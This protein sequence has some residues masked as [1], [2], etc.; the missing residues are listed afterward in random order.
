MSQ[1]TSIVFP[2][3]SF[4][5]IMAVLAFIWIV[6]VKD[7]WNAYH[8]RGWKHVETSE[9]SLDNDTEYRGESPLTLYRTYPVP[10][11]GAP[12]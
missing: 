10:L 3:M 11:V 7:S 1:V 4:S 2:R 9:L 5:V 12:K 6:S 8:G